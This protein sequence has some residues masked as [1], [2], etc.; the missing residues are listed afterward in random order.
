MNQSRKYLKVRTLL[1]N[2]LNNLNNTRKSLEDPRAEK[3]LNLGETRENQSKT[4]QDRN[5]GSPLT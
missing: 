5:L 2:M 1:R 3:D 4:F